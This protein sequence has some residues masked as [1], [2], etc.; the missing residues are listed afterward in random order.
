MKLKLSLLLALLAMLPLALPADFADDYLL[1][2]PQTVITAAKQPLQWTN[3]DWQTAGGVLFIAGGLYLFDEEIADLITR[4]RSAFTKDLAYAGNQFGDGKYVVPALGL[5]YLGGAV[6]KSSHTQDT[7]LL[8]LK[9][10]LL[11]N[12]M[13]TSLKY[14]TQRHRPFSR[15]GKQFWNGN[16]FKHS[17]DSFPSG[18]STV[19]WSVAPI[20]AEQYKDHKWV[21]PT[22]YSIAVL[23]SY[24]RMHDEKHWSSDVFCGA[25]IG[26]L[27]SQLV[28]KTTPRLDISYSAN[29]N[30]ILLGFDF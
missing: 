13:T 7:A 26:Y 4:N 15:K 24:A 5:T 1:S 14:L 8:S 28:L 3:K 25:V 29:P 2:Y 27:T 18:H 16:G 6:L 17:R 20:L 19:V 22:A 10:F 11:A 30:Q 21:A 12:G 9:S 23:T